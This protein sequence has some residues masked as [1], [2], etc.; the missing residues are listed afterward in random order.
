MRL[1]S[2]EGEALPI[3]K[4]MDIKIAKVPGVEFIISCLTGT[5]NNAKKKKSAEENSSEEDKINKGVAYFIVIKEKSI[6]DEIR[7]VISGAGFKPKVSYTGPRGENREAT[8]KSLNKL[9][10]TMK[11]YFSTYFPYLFVID[12]PKLWSL[13]FFSRLRIV[14]NFNFEFSRIFNYWHNRI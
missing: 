9:R 4:E 12:I 13:F 10:I 14:S 11:V 3:R 1:V 7:R 2:P 8:D 6:E 5:K